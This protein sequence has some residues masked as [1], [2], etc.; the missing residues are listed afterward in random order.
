M[1]SDK[2]KS[3]FWESSV[4]IYPPKFITYSQ[5]LI[6]K[7]KRE[8]QELVKRIF[9]KDHCLQKLD[10]SAREQNG[11]FGGESIISGLAQTTNAQTD[12]LPNTLKSALNPIYSLTQSNFES[13]LLLQRPKAPDNTITLIKKPVDIFIPK[14]KPNLRRKRASRNF[15]MGISRYSLNSDS[16][17]RILSKVYPEIEASPAKL[18]P[19]PVIN[20]KTKKLPAKKLLVKEVVKEVVNKVPK[21][22]YLSFRTYIYRLWLY[23]KSINLTTKGK[24]W[25]G[26]S[27]ILLRKESLKLK[28]Q[29]FHFF[30]PP[31]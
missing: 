30:V 31:R 10:N 23:M 20:S 1:F 14:V 24:I 6:E 29:T 2:T 21:P 11:I 18:I 17:V 22:V 26:I 7:A 12:I 9:D 4:A 27:S 15:L 25:N 5:Y 19:I 3:P 13:D 16:E 8:E 28:I